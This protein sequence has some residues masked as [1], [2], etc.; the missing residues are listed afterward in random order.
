MKQITMRKYLLLFTLLFT[1]FKQVKATHNRAGEITFTCDPQNP[2]H[3]FFTIITYTKADAQ[4]DRCDLTVYFCNLNDSANFYRVNGL[5]GNCPPPAKMGEIIGNNI[6][7]NVYK[8][9]HTFSGSVLNCRIMVEDPN[10]NENIVNIP[11]SVNVPFFLVSTFSISPNIGCNTS[12]VLLNPPVE[13]ACYCKKFIHN[14]GAYDA[15]GDSLSYKLIN[16]FTSGGQEIP[17]YTLPIGVAIN[18][19]NGDL[20]WD[21]PGS[22]S[23]SPSNCSGSVS[24]AGEYN[25]AILIEEWRNGQLI[26]SVERDM[27]VTVV[28]G[29]SNNPPI[30]EANDTC[31]IAGTTLNMNI[32]AYDQP[33]VVN[34]ITK[35]DLVTLTGSGGPF[36]LQTSPAQFAGA[37]GATDVNATFSWSTICQHI[38]RRPYN[39]S[40]KVVD[41]NDVNELSDI[42]TIN[43]SVIGPA[44]ILTSATPSA[45][46]INLVWQAYQCSNAIGYKIYRKFGCSNS[47]IDNCKT[48]IPEGEGYTYL[49]TI[50]DINTL[51]YTDNDNGIGLVYGQD[52]SYRMFAYFSDSAESRASMERCARLVRNA[53]IIT[54]I[55]IYKTDSFVG[56]DTLKWARPTE[57]DSVNIFPPPYR[58]IINRGYVGE[59]NLAPIDSVDGINTTIY[60]K[61]SLLNTETKQLEYRIDFY[62][63]PN[64]LLVGKSNIATSVWLDTLAN[65][66]QIQLDFKYSVPWI[67]DTFYV[68]RETS[69]GSNSF[70]LRAITQNKTYT[71]FNL[72]NNRKYCYRV[73]S[74]GYYSDTTLPK[75]LYNMSQKICAVPVDRTAPCAPKLYAKPDCANFQSHLGWTNPNLSCADDVIKYN[76]YFSETENGTMS[77][78]KSFFNANDT[79]FTTEADSLSIAG[80]YSITALDSANNE[81]V[82]SDTI[83]V[84]NCPEY[85][86]PNVFTPNGDNANDFFIPFPYRFVKDVSMVIYDRWG[87]LVFETTNPRIGWNGKNTKSNVE[88]D[89]GV[90]YYV[91]K[92]NEIKLK[93]ITPRTI[94]GYIVKMASE[95][96]SKTF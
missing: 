32:H 22:S 33:I 27:Q 36:L 29:C 25:F 10:R 81:S 18:P 54:N 65:D 8:G 72:V 5:S 40:F 64:H 87:N 43:I 17:C 67:N 1:V 76:L 42:K 4:A 20:T 52:Y 50:D 12:P 91:C 28:P 90:F 2:Y 68:Y 21:C 58:Y 30:V 89:D 60:L 78:Y 84:D 88:C 46:A 80:C 79:S 96:N 71:E 51:S 38:R 24:G 63:V 13:N 34:N 75:P 3:Y 53:P 49:T 26:G 7:K 11:N 57:F 15:D 62:S 82:F 69:V 70:I 56:K 44:P 74:K 85:Y 45:N 41:N 16:P 66:R 14:P 23:P 95:K 73:L 35:I 48:G 6:R 55:S 86:L 19:I 94:K 39:V 93:G 92:V 61:D 77:L 47:E 83:C 59:N 37:G 9:E 31:V